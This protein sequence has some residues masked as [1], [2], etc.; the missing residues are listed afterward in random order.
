MHTGGISAPG[1]RAAACS[2]SSVLYSWDAQS[3]SRTC[4]YTNVC[5]YP[6][7]RGVCA[8]FGVFKR[9]ARAAVTQPTLPTITPEPSY[10]VPAAFLAVAGVLVVKGD[11]VPAAVVG[12]LGGALTVLVNSA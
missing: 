7:S 5:I 6:A 10:N 12:V 4:P 2:A 3:I 1:R 9:K 11:L 8:Q